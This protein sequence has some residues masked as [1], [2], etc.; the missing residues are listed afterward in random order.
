MTVNSGFIVAGGAYLNF[1]IILGAEGGLRRGNE[2]RTDWYRHTV[3]ELT[4]EYVIKPIFLSASPT[5]RVSHIST[6]RG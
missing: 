4:N 2:V 1:L 5:P 6:V 3:L